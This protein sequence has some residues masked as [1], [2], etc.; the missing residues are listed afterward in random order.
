MSPRKAR[1]VADMIRGKSVPKA[2]EILAFTDKR[3][4][5]FMI[6]T[7][8]SA[9]ANAGR[10]EGVDTDRLAV[11]AAMVNEG[12]RLKGRFLPRPRGMATP[13][14]P[15]SCHIHLEVSEPVQP[16]AAAG[17]RRS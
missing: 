16:S 17:T 15:P 1:L 2:L 4:A 13:I 9:V 8:K 6:K 11:S 12:P 5:S 14:T 3:A 10:D 7:L